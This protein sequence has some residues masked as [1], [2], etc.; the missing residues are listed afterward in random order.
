MTELPTPE[1]PLRIGTRASPLAMAQAHMA[2]AALIAGHGLPAEAPEI[3]PMTA[4]GDRI[5]DRP[6]AEA[7]G[8]ASWTPEHHAALAAGLP[9][10]PEPSRQNVATPPP[11]PS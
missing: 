11:P 2:I 7:R 3:V 8:K 5:Q 10:T 4:T 9:A 1:N 6:P